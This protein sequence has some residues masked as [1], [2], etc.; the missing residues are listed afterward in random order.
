[1]IE[2]V[3]IN[4]NLNFVPFVSVDHMMKIIGKIGIENM[5]K[6]IATYIEEDFKRWKL[7]DKTPRVAA[8]SDKGVIELMPT[9]DSLGNLLP[10]QPAKFLRLR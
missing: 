4:K 6:G 2:N 10:F 3:Q 8:H 1:M 9:S 7:F 5:L